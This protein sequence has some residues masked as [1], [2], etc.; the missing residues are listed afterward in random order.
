MAAAGWRSLAVMRRS[1][2]H[3]D[4][5]GVFNAIQRPG[6]T[7]GTQPVAK[8]GHTNTLGSPHIPVKNMRRVQRN[9]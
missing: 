5:Q 2:Q 8:A 3:T 4:A 6:D 9:G 7:P 1:D